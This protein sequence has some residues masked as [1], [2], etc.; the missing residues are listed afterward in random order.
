[1]KA[2]NLMISFV[3]ALF[4]VAG[5]SAHSVVTGDLANND[6]T[7]IVKANGMNAEAHD[8]A[9]I[10]GEMVSITVKFTANQSDT[11]VTVEVTLE[12]DKDKVYAST[13][14]FDVEAGHRYSKTLSLKVPFE[15]KDEISTGLDL[16]VEIDGKAYKTEVDNMTLSVQRPSYN[17]DVKSITVPSTITAGETFP[18]EIVLK[19][20]GYNDLDDVY[21]SANIE[22]LGL[23]QNNKWFGDLLNLENNSNHHNDEDETAV[24]KLALTVP[25]TAEAGVYTL[26]IVV[27]NDDTETVAVKQIVITNDYSANIIAATTAKTAAKG[28]EVTYDLLIVN[29]TDNVKVYKI[30]TEGDVSSTVSQSVIAVPAG[31]SKTVKV[32]ASSNVEGENTF[33]LHVFEGES[34][35]ETIAYSLSVEGKAV[36]T[37]FVLTIVLAVIFLVL[38]VAL[39][40]LLGKRPEKSEEFGESYY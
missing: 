6:N 38:L 8:V 3:L 10:A 34:L 18:I 37:V 14:S 20:M 21:V 25:Y 5:A 11:D 24:G 15:L 22:E 26:E 31:S 35:K 9:V 7:L 23:S 17:A 36:N 12:G 19:N 40:V 16:E 33:A 2:K 29:P 1:M 13:E 27:T 39:I 30:V 32:T 4:L 28:Q